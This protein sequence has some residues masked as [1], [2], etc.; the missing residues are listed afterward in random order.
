MKTMIQTDKLNMSDTSE[1]F[2]SY[3]HEIHSDWYKSILNNHVRHSG[4]TIIFFIANIKRE[5]TSP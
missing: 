5:V 1:S 3:L 4:K 2:D